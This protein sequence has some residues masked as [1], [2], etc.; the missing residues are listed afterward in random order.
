MIDQ[1]LLSIFR[2]HEVKA[3]EKMY[4]DGI[5]DHFIGD[6]ALWKEFKGFVKRSGI[7]HEIAW[8]IVLIHI[9]KMSCR[10]ILLGKIKE[11]FTRHVGVSHGERVNTRME[12]AQGLAQAV[13]KTLDFLNSDAEDDHGFTAAWARCESMRRMD[14]WSAFINYVEAT[15]IEIQQDLV[16]IDCSIEHISVLM[17]LFLSD[18]MIS[19]ES[20]HQLRSLPELSSLAANPEWCNDMHPINVS[21]WSEDIQRIVALARKPSNP[22]VRPLG[23]NVH[24]VEDTF[25]VKHGTH[26]TVKEAMAIEYVR[27]NSSIPVPRI[28][29]VLGHRGIIHI[30][31]ARVD[32]DDLSRVLQSDLLSANQIQDIIAQLVG[33]V[34]E[35]RCIGGIRD[36]ISS[37]P[38][39]VP[40]CGFFSPPPSRPI[41]SLQDFYKYWVDRFVEAKR[42]RAVWSE[43]APPGLGDSVA[44]ILSHGDLAPRNIMVRGARIAAIVDWETFGWY[45]EFWEGMMARRYWVHKVWCGEMSGALPCVGEVTESFS[46]V[47]NSACAMF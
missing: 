24:Q 40:F 12:T 32:A 38:R 5:Y 17:H 15:S 11:V 45:P 6:A 43:S 47:V 31:M 26:V 42:Y 18:A 39:G 20:E 19:L 21:G 22:R 3:Y 25:I 33:Y 27:R 1:E 37:W 10:G 13:I 44:T 23:P 36:E 2:E 28:L 34:E 29:G 35:L 41:K 16:A 14:I 30:V 9:D 46:L 7:Q 8:D 4:V